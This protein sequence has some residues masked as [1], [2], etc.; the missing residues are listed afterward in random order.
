MYARSTTIQADPNRLDEGI[1][2]VRDDVMPTLSGMDGCVGLSMI[3]DRTSGRSITTTAWRDEEAMRA[4]DAAARPL[5]ER[6]G[7]V[8]AGKPE[9]NV[10]EIA[11]LHRVEE[12]GEGACVR[13]SW[14]RADSDRIQRAVEA[15][16]TQSLPAI[17]GLPGIRSASLFVDRDQGRAVVSTTYDSRASLERSRDAATAL[18]GKLVQEQGVE[19]LEVGEFD[20]VLAHLRVPETV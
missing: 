13:V 4:S 19:V 1:A 11:V 20:L 10:W 15:F 2:Y 16:R 9:V 18:R 6:A 7:Q 12:A 8:F 17:E 5:R 14:L 3:V